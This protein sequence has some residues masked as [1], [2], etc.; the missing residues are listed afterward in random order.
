MQTTAL[1]HEAYLWL[2]NQRQG[3]WHNRVQFLVDLFALNEAL[4]PPAGA[5]SR[6][7]GDLANPCTLR[8]PLW[9]LEELRKVRSNLFHA[10]AE[11][12]LRIG[13]KC[14]VMLVGGDRLLAL[15]H[16][17]GETPFLPQ[18]A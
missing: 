2:V 9:L 8:L 16:S 6:R 1:V 13:P 3:N 15:S 12:G 17:G 11:T 18:V 14:Q 10:G 4:T 7:M 5:P